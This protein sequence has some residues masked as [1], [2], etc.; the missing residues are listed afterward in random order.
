[1]VADRLQPIEDER[2]TQARKVFDSEVSNGAEEI[3][4]TTK[5]GVDWHD[6]VTS[7]NFGSWLSQQ[8]VSVQRAATV[9]DSSEA[10]N[11]LRRYEDDYQRS[12]QAKTDVETKKTQE[13]QTTKADNIKKTRTQ[14]QAAGVAPGSKPSPSA[15]NEGGGDYEAEF[16]ARWG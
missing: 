2:T 13:E 11:V 7:N 15:G 12:V 9:R 16:N 6:V 1:M 14:R 4:D 10:L 5:T 3:F 8:P